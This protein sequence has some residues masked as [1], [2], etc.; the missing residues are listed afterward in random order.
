[1]HHAEVVLDALLT[2]LALGFGVV[3]LW[4]AL[5]LEPHWASRDGRRMTARVQ[6][7]STDGSVEGR[8]QEVRAAVTQDG[9]LAT[10]ARGLAN[11]RVTGRW[12]PMSTT[13]DEPRRKVVYVLR[14]AEGSTTSTERLVLRIPV[15]SR[16]RPVLDAMAAQTPPA[17][18]G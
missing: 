8:W 12:T 15:N 2:L 14:R 10:R 13:L 16:A 17:S 9:Y 11:A 5:R 1:M 18:R 3:A 6:V 4:W 7:M